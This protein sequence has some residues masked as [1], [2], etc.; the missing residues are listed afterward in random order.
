VASSRML[1]RV[2]CVEAYRRLFGRE[3][4][5]DRLIEVRRE[6]AKRD[7]FYLLV[8]VL[9][10]GDINHDWIYERCREVEAA[11]DGYL[12]LWGREH[13]KSSIITFGLTIRDI[14]RDPEITVGIFSYSRPIAKA[15]LRQIKRE[16]ENN[17]RLRGLFPDVLWGDPQRDAPKWSEDEGIIVRRVGNPK[18][19][20][21]EAWGLV[22]GQPTSKHF[23]LMVYDDVVTRDSVTNPE[24][25]AKVNEAWQTSRNL[26]ADGGVTRYIGTRWHHNDTYRHILDRK[27]AVERRHPATRDG[28]EDGEPVLFSRERLL[29]KRREMGGYVFSSQMLL[30]PTADRAQGFRYEWL[31]FYQPRGDFTG[32]NKYLLVDPASEKKK[33]SD[34]TAMMVVGLGSDQNYYVLDMVRDRLNLPQRG[35]AV[36][37]LHRRWKPLGVG[38]EKYGMMA[39]VEYLKERMDRESYHFGITELGGQTPKNDRIRRL[40]PV[41]EAGRLWLPQSLHKVDYEGRLVD[42]VQAFIEEEYKA[43]PVGVHDDML[44]TLA[45]IREEDLKTVWPQAG[46]QQDDRYAR[47]RPGRYFKSG[48]DPYAWTPSERGFPGPSHW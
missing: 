5:P 3:L 34:Y 37:A 44:D 36:F 11:P 48:Y 42:L 40:V 17:E 12:D 13:Y 30:D 25:I 23:R 46:R 10:R 21:V 20:T 41:C 18:E 9:R 26:T 28:T 45:R 24:M 33:T 47:R 15:F 7:L 4:D 39:D 35:D 22:D 43:F 6:L 8:Y 29:E 27:A 14:L 31:R 1:S 19:S 32:M 2:E 16:F 38:Y